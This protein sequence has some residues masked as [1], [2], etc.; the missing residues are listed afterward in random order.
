[1]NICTFWLL[2]AALVAGLL[3]RDPNTGSLP[4][5]CDWQYFCPSRTTCCRHPAGGWGCCPLRHAHCCLD[6]YHCCPTGHHCDKTY[7]RCLKGDL[8]YPFFLPKPATMIKAVKADDYICQ[9][10]K[11]SHK[12]SEVFKMFSQWLKE[13]G[14]DWSTEQY[15]MKVTN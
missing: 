4:V 3:A 10:P 2:M 5:H 1:M 6:G 13:R 11:T 9:L 15:C 12:N 8:P 14:F 7:S